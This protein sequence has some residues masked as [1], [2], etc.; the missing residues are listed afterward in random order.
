M[1]HKIYRVAFPNEIKGIKSPSREN[2]WEKTKTNLFEFLKSYEVSPDLIT[3]TIAHH[4]FLQSKS[5]ECVYQETSHNIVRPLMATRRVIEDPDK[6][7][8]KNF[9]FGCFLDFLVRCSKSAFN[10]K[11]D[12]ESLALLLEKMELSE[13]FAKQNLR[14]Y[15][16]NT[17]LL[18][19]KRI[20]ELLENSQRAPTP[21]T[22]KSM[23]KK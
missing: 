7:L 2:D 11:V 4:A 14:T 6:I 8:G 16:S 12:G 23:P 10:K 20:V 5:G 17:T 9:T 1:L 19:S 13:G 15:T 21:A 18:P 3:K 22:R